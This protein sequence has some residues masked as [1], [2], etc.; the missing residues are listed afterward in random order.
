MN[1]QELNKIAL[2]IIEKYGT[3][4]G[5]ELLIRLMQEINKPAEVKIDHETKPVYCPY[6]LTGYPSYLAP[7]QSHEWDKTTCS[8]SQ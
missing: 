1:Q 5:V 3:E 8:S 4:K 6:P 7:T 2:A